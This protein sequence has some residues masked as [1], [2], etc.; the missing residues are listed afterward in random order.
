M[1][2]KSVNTY[3]KQKEP[4]RRI[5]GRFPVNRIRGVDWFKNWQETTKSNADINNNA[6]KK[7]K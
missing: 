2:N 1:Q 7:K 4:G 3:L 6:T 5:P